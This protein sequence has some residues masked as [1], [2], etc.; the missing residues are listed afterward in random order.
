MIFSKELEA[1]F[2]N[3]H[4]WDS[5]G[6]IIVFG[7]SAE[8]CTSVKLYIATSILVTGAV[9]YYMVEYLQHRKSKVEP[10]DVEDKSVTNQIVSDQNLESKK[11]S[12]NVTMS[13]KY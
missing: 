3:F 12:D 5:L 10:F 2:A 9:G 8:L 4:M 7:Y 6:V 11:T 13:E 1:A